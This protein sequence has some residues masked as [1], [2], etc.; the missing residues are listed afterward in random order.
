MDGERRQPAP[1]LLPSSARRP[2]A[3]LAWCCLAVTVVLA[4]LS[5]HSARPNALDRPVDNWLRGHLGTH[6]AALTPVSNLGGGLDSTL[7]TAVIVVA[8][9]TLRRFNGALLAL[10]SAVAVAGLIEFVIKRVVHE[11][12]N[13]DLV[14][15]SGHTASVFAAAT[16]LTVLLLNPPR[17]NARPAVTIA[18][19]VL[20]G[21]VG[22]LVA[23]AMISLDYHYFTD[24]IGGAAFATAVVIAV[25]FL[26]DSGMVRRRLGSVG[27]PSR[28]PAQPEREEAPASGRRA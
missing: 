17:H 6:P 25:T 7:I 22:C 4:V 1:P 8:C 28:R 3:V 26:L 23:V 19:A 11:T 10:V 5:A 18:V 2:A 12:L 13:G 21:L 27:Y 16:V 9:L 20:T 24:T 15:P 14:Y